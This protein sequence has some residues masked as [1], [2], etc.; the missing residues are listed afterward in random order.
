[1]NNIDVNDFDIEKVELVKIQIELGYSYYTLTYDR[2]LFSLVTQE[3][4]L[5][6][7]A[8]CGSVTFYIVGNMYKALSQ[9]DRYLSTVVTNYKPSM[10]LNYIKARSL[11]FVPDTMF[12]A[13]PQ[14]IFREVLI[15]T[16]KSTLD[17]RI[18]ITESDKLLACNFS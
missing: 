2:S 15:G 18:N 8:N 7:G 16:E 3:K 5:S 12:T 17:V 13:S 11:K 9:I 10:P 6:P 1:M 4:L 14:I